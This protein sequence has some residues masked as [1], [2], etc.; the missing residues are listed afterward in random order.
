M[1]LSYRRMISDER[2][3]PAAAAAAAMIRTRISSVFICLVSEVERCS[4]TSD[5][6]QSCR[7]QDYGTPWLWSELGRSGKRSYGERSKPN[8]LIG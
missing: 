3:K 8:R 7:L 5:R 2:I 4:D 6:N 1:A